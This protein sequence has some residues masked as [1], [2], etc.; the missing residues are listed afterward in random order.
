MMRYLEKFGCHPNNCKQKIDSQDDFSHSLSLQ[1]K[2]DYSFLII[3]NQVQ[4][5][6]H[7]IINSLKEYLRNIMMHLQIL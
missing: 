1:D 7:V 3:K 2:S 5:L 4:T 6:N